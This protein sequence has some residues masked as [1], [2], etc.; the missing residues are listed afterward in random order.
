M[1]REILGNVPDFKMCVP[2]DLEI[3]LPVTYSKKTII[4]V[5]RDESNGRFRC[6]LLCNTATAVWWTGVT[7]WG[8]WTE[9][10]SAATS[11][12]S[13]HFL[14]Q[15]DADSHGVKASGYRA[16]VEKDRVCTNYAYECT[17]RD[18]W[19]MSSKMSKWLSFRRKMW[20]NFNFLY[21]FILTN[22]YKYIIFIRRRKQDGLSHTFS[23]HRSPI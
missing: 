1:V 23:I 16:S 9:N 10:R 6:R 14:T 19:K 11:Q 3:L 13:G 22:F 18:T 2:F 17:C 8:I 21:I 5:C 12:R 20:S 15:E 7:V 4:K